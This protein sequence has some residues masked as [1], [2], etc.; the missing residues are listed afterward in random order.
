MSTRKGIT[1]TMLIRILNNLILQRTFALISDY[2][3]YRDFQCPTK[4]CSLEIVPA[5]LSQIFQNP[6]LNR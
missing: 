3:I 2:K 6:R 5:N 4:N 1:V